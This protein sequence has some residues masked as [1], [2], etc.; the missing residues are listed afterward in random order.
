M[1]LTGVRVVDLTRVVAGP[2]CTGLL[3]DMGAEVIKVESPKEPDPVRAQGALRDGLSWYFAQFNRNKKAIT[4]DLYTDEGKDILARLLANADVLA[5]NYRPGVLDRMGFPQSRL[6]AINPGLIVTEIT[7]FGT[8]GPYAERPAFDFIAQA[9]SGFMSVNGG[10]DDPPLRA[11][12]PMS[13]LTAGLYAAFGTACAL[14]GRA[15]GTAPGQRVESSLMMGLV[16]L[17]SYLSASWFATGELPERVGNNHVVVAPYGLFRCS[18]GELGVAPSNDRVVAKFMEALGLTA[19]L[20]DPDFATN[21][22]RLKHRDRI[23][24][25]VDQVMSQRSR[26]HWIEALNRA[27]VPAGRVMNVGEVLTDPQVLA[28]D[29]VLDVDH[30]GHGT[31]RMTGF[32]VKLTRTP[33][34]I[35]RPA[36]AHG[37]HTDEILGG[38]GL[39]V[40]ALADLRRRG[41]V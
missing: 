28:Q 19:L 1:P 34:H 2:F 31:V 11:G 23:H 6:D 30:P 21:A 39:T 35:R 18:D 24:A 5:I 20:A 13:D 33:A 7:G 16:S 40:E 29:M 4:L 25:A 32:P 37:Q 3:A 8:S 22:A 41:V 12:P 15:R 38:L 36:P 10:P 26:D 17:L 27:G 9:M 14:A